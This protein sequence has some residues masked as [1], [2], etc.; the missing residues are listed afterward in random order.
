MTNLGL[1]I[2]IEH[3][4]LGGSVT[5]FPMAAQVLARAVLARGCRGHNRVGRAA[6]TLW[7]ATIW[8]GSFVAR[9]RRWTRID[10]SSL[11]GQIVA[12]DPAGL[13]PRAAGKVPA[14]EQ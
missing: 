5:C 10:P 7:A 12:A 1:T 6:A 2:Q 8:P 11:S 3:L 9:R 4:E 14:L 13:L